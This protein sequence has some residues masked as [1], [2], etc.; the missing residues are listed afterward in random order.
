MNVLWYVPKFGSLPIIFS[1]DF[2]SPPRLPSSYHPT[3]W[4]I[5]LKTYWLKSRFVPLLYS[6]IGIV[7]RNI[8]ICNFIPICS[9]SFYLLSSI[10]KINIYSK[11]CPKRYNVGAVPVSKQHRI[12]W[13]PHCS[14][15]TSQPQ[16]L[17][18]PVIKILLFKYLIIQK[19]LGSKV[20]VQRCDF[21]SDF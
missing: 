14:W 2:S 5:P 3:Y 16:N 18:R 7:T 11:L 21:S 20:S 12:I 6:T 8:L 9:L 10:L 1:T 15:W 17:S 19:R 13:P 4:N